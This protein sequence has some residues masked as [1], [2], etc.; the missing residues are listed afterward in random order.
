MKIL[1]ICQYYYPEPFRINTLCEEMVRR[2][3]E[4]L[5]VTGEP[6]YPEGKI[7]E[8]YKNHQHAD[9]VVRDV[10]VHRCPIIP[11]KTGT[12][13]RILNYYSYPFEAKR[14][15]LSKNCI[16]SDGKPFDVVFV[17]QLSPVMMAEPAIAYKQKYNVP[18]LLYCLDLWPESLLAGGI[19]RQS[20]PYKYFHSVSKNIY[21]KIDCILVT[22]KLFKNYLH[23]EFSVSKDKIVYLPQYAET[24]FK[25]LSPCYN[26]SMT[27][28]VFA[29]N[30][31][32]VQNVETILYAA[33]ELTDKPVRFHIVGGGTDLERLQKIT[34]QKKLKNVQF[35]G[36]R[37]LEEMPS[38]YEKA[39]AMLITL[40]ADPVLSLTLPGKIQSYMA[41][42]KPIIGAIDGEA[43]EIIKTA[44]CGFVGKA[45]NV[46]QLVK[47]IKLFLDCNNQ[48]KIDFGKRARSFYE[49]YFSEMQFMD[50]L[51][52]TIKKVCTIN[53]TI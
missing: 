33:E 9:E 46:E 26:N 42:G 38:F 4:V 17:N 12:L 36:R 47:N 23:K 8:G 10:R 27:N 20:V 19:K 37:P 50:K 13:Y 51:E 14:F 41:A 52:A 2:G 18:I 21:T 40:K 3:H 35:Y 53:E 45:E 44:E 1:V 7:Y 34:I 43:A 15:V 31:G 29:G 22:S 28:L 49:S 11:R 5:V 48:E 16:A 25:E 24:V 39:D 30:I 32:N 6:N